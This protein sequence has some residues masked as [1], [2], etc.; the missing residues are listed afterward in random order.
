MGIVIPCKFQNIDNNVKKQQENNYTMINEKYNLDCSCFIPYPLCF[1]LLAFYTLTLS[2]CVNL[3]I[4][5]ISLS[6]IIPSDLVVVVTLFPTL[7]MDKEQ[8][9][10]CGGIFSASA[11]LTFLFIYSG[12]M[13]FPLKK[14]QQKTLM[15][16]FYQQS[17]KFLIYNMPNFCYNQRIQ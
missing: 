4:V 14:P 11:I 9:Y 6:R 15:V 16:S 2:W 13:A 10:I 8:V 5:P 7:P 17:Y 1:R 12:F 3:P